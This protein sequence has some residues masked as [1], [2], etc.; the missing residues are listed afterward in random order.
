[1]N[2]DRNLCRRLLFFL[3][4]KAHLVT[5]ISVLVIL[6][7]TLLPFDFSIPYNLSFRYIFSTFQQSTNLNDFVVNI[8]LFIPFGLGLAAFLSPRVNAKYKVTTLVF[9][10]SLCLTLTVE[11]CQI[12]LISRNSTLSD[13]LANSSG[14]LL[15]GIIFFWFKNFNQQLSHK[16][17][18]FNKFNVP[19]IRLQ[20]LTIF[21]LLYFF[22]MTFMLLT[23]QDSTKLSNWDPKFHL[24]IGNETLGDRPWLGKVS[25]L[26]ITKN[27]LDPQQIKQL[28]PTN[29]FCKT[30]T[31]Q[32]ENLI[33]A[34]L[35]N[36]SQLTYSDL[37]NNLSN[38][39]NQ[40]KSR[41]PASNTAI[42]VNSKHWLQTTSPATKLTEEIQNSSQFTI[43]TKIA[44]ANFQQ[45]GPARIVS[46]SYDH[47]WRN[48]TISQWRDALIFRVRMPLT[49]TNGKKP[50]IRINNF[51]T[52]T[53]FHQLAIAYNGLRLK[54]Y[55]DNV[56]NVKSLY[57]GSEAALFWTVFSTIAE[58]MPLNVD[59]NLFYVLL[60]YIVIFAPLGIFWGLIF[61]RLRTR[62]LGLSILIIT[63]LI[64]PPSIVEAIIINSSIRSWSWSFL[65]LGITVLTIS[66]LLTIGRRLKNNAK[67]SPKI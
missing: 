24:M 2:S 14:G 16:L 40:R 43:F 38:L 51:F 20:S 50:E 61:K 54:F 18:F 55:L 19:F 23:V 37:T 36:D 66:F 39:D 47:L 52:D 8:F 44:T 7:V 15:G 48:F 3:E 67:I 45:E 65:V 58:K 17:L 11:L 32:P 1:M 12:F 59:S 6:G 31:N 64:L 46:L 4:K 9:L 33:T 53:E 42:E 29:K 56:N 25:S 34:Y 41:T 27:A 49:G 22:L 57:L 10:V 13:V 21:W 5:T 30:L 60:Y 26:C 62:L 35:F 28:L 63:G